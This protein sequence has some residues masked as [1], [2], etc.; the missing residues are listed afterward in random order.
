MS[1]QVLVELSRI[2]VWDVE[3]ALERCS[4]IIVVSHMLIQNFA[5]GV[6]DVPRNV[7][8]MPSFMMQIMEIRHGSILI[9]VRAAVVV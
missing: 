8:P 6:R 9:N 2:S 7:V 1:R 3:A 5:G 4:S